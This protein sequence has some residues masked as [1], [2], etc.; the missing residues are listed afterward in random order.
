LLV[1]VLVELVTVVVVE[2]AVIVAL[3]LVKH[4]VVEQAQNHQLLYQLELILLPLVTVEHLNLGQ[5][6]T[7]LVKVIQDKTHQL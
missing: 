4:L 5:L 3:F 1:E 2:L 6:Q 7:L